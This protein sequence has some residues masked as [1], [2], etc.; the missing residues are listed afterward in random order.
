MQEMIGDAD[1]AAFRI[2]LMNYLN[3]NYKPKH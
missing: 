1:N 2:G 3:A